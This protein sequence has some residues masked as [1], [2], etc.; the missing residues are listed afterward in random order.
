MQY[1]QHN[2]QRGCNYLGLIRMKDGDD[3][4]FQVHAFA[5]GGSY[6][7]DRGRETPQ[8]GR[9]LDFVMHTRFSM[10]HI[11]SQWFSGKIRAC[12]ARAPCS[13]HGCDNVLPEGGI[14]FNIFCS[15]CNLSK[16]TGG[17][18]RPHKLGETPFSVSDL[19]PTHSPDSSQ[20]LLLLS[21]TRSRG[22]CA[23]GR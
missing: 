17:G 2:R 6:D 21:V 13:I 4:S 10:K 15:S 1:T 5:T 20:H 23:S 12:H 9:L 7:R 8:P 11:K 19:L 14:P 16:P 18:A 22:W 3:P